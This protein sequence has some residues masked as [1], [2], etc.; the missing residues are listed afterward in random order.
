MQWTKARIHS[1]I[2]SGLRAASRR[3]PPKYE[4]LAEAAVGIKTNVK[5]G[6]LAKHYKCAHCKGEFPGSEIDIDH[7]IPVVDPATGFT[8]WDSFINRLFCPKENFAA[9]CKPCHKIK[10]K[11]ENNEIQKCD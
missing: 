5:T 6:R 1:F 10:T 4:T 9:L 11:M 7:T 2:V 3:W 8:T